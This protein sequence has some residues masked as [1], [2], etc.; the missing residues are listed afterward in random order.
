MAYLTCAALGEDFFNPNSFFATYIPLQ[1]GDGKYFWMRQ[2]SL[3]S[4]IDAAGYIV[5][6]FNMYR[7]LEPFGNLRPS[8]PMIVIDG[9]IRRDLEQQVSRQTEMAM[10]AAFE[11]QLK[12]PH[13]TTFRAYR[14]QFE[15]S[16]DRPPTSQAI[17][18]ALG[19]RVSTIHTY[20][21]HILEAARRTF[22][23][24]EFKSV[25]EFLSFLH[26]VFGGSNQGTITEE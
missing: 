17:A 24:V 7:L 11:E 6:L 26:T 25:G 14:A 10:L 8:R 13:L 21:K 22:P 20:N 3:A 15:Q 19:H 5:T 23:A 16:P 4:E 2:L 1:R 18:R 12:V 9:S